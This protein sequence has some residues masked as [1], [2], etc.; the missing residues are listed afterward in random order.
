MDFREGTIRPAFAESP[1]ERGLLRKTL[2]D[3]FVAKRP[4]TKDEWFRKISHDL[5]DRT[6]PRQVGQYLATV[7]QIIAELDLPGESERTGQLA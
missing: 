6:D 5:R 1:Q 7:L 3:E 2:L 4:K